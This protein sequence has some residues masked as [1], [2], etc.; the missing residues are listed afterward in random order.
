MSPSPF[1][2]RITGRAAR[3]S[4]FTGPLAANPAYPGIGTE[5]L[6]SLANCS[7][8]ITPWGTALSCEENYQDYP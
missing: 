5:A 8:G 3:R 6:G 1:N 2:R 7:G 4:Q